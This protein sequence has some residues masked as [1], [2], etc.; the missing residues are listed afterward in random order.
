LRKSSIN[1]ACHSERSEESRLPPENFFGI[2]RGARNDNSAGLRD[3][4]LAR[5]LDTKKI[6]T[7]DFKNCPTSRRFLL[8]FR[9][10][11]AR[12]SVAQNIEA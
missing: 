1:G 2:P 6:V 7:R 12:L 11:I 5:A 8:I 9:H 10:I 4:T 3:A